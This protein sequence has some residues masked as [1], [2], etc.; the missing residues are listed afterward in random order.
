MKKKA[1]VTLNY[2]QISLNTHLISSAAQVKM[3]LYNSDLIRRSQ[4]ENTFYFYYLYRYA[5]EDITRL[6]KHVQD[7]FG[8]LTRL[9]DSRLQRLEKC[10]QLKHFDEE[11]SKVGNSG[12]V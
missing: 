2:H 11:C 5:M 7:T 1:K 3:N 4:K 8:K 6:F 9:S 10:L 12:V